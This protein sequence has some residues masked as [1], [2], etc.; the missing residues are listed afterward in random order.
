ERIHA[1]GGLV[2]IPHPFARGKGGGGRILM[3]IGDAVDIVEGF[4]ARLHEPVLN[5]RAQ[6]WARNAD[7]PLG[8]G[9]DAHTLKEIGRAWVDVLPFDDDPRSFLDALDRAHIHGTASPRRVHVASTWA[10][11]RK[12]WKG[13]QA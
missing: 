2:Y 12:R 11:I 7:K 3:E 8:A 1:Q 6:T 9:S 13:E 5:E 4:N 10:K